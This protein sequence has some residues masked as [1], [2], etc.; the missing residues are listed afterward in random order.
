MARIL[1]IDDDGQTRNILREILT[2]RRHTLVEAPDRKE[3]VESYANSPAD[4]VITDI[5]MPEE[6]SLEG[7]QET[8]VQNFLD[9]PFNATDLAAAVDQALAG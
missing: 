2:P 9:K 5:V 4:L 8:G 7:I 3:G 6:D 1:V